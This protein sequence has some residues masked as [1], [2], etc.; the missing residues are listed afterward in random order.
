MDLTRYVYENQD[1]NGAKIFDVIN[2]L[3]IDKDT[4][5]GINKDA[6]EP[7]LFISNAYSSIAG[8]RS[9]TRSKR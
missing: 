2:D 8:T 3:S 9:R 5:E 4:C 7:Y 1:Y 6:L